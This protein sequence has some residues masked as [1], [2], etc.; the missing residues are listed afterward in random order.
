MPYEVRLHREVVK[1]LNGMDPQ[2]RSKIIG[3]LIA[4]RTDPFQSRSGADIVRLTGTKG[5]QGL[6]RLRVGE[7]RAIYAVENTVVYVTDLFYRGKGYQQ[8]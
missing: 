6:F 3:A 2:L 1:A 8:H 4:L 5:K 7:Y